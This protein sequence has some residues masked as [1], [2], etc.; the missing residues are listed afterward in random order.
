MEDV[1]DL[2]QERD[3]GGHGNGIA[4]KSG[5][6]PPAVPVLVQAA[7]ALAHRF[8]KAQRGG[9]GGAP[10][11]A[12]LD[13]LRDL[14]LA[15]A[16]DVE[17]RPQPVAERGLASGMRQHEAEH[18]RQAGAHGLEVALQGQIV[19]QIQLADPR[20]IAGAA[21]VLEEDGEIKLPQRIVAEPHVPAD[22][23]PDPGRARAMSD[24]LAFGEVEREGQ[25]TQK[26]REPNRLATRH[27][28]HL[29]YLHA[30]PLV[31]RLMPIVLARHGFQALSSAGTGPPRL[32][33]QLTKR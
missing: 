31:R 21:E 8:G 27:R 10:V 3:A 6:P 12:R 15:M 28:R 18:L 29:S 7:D 9:D 26:L 30:R 25:G 5:R 22:R 16:G 32:K 2:R 20:G 19:R 13:D 24:R 11:A 17:N 33:E 23:Q 4:R 1:D 14:G